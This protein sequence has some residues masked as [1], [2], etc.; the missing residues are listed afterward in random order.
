MLM[1][2]ATLIPGLGKTT[3]GAS[4]WIPIGPFSLQPSELIK[5]FLVLQAAYLFARWHRLEEKFAGLVNYFCTGIGS[6]FKT[7]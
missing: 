7:T 2:F 1:I 3:L 5:P 4:R 6:N